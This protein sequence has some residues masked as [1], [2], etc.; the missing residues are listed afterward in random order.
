MDPEAIRA[1]A[2]DKDAAIMLGVNGERMT[3]VTFGLGAALVGA[4]SR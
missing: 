2:Q 3:L 1:T 4:A